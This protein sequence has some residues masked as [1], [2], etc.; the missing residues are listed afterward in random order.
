MNVLSTIEIGQPKTIV[1]YHTQDAT[2]LRKLVTL[3]MMPG[4]EIILEQR[5]PSYI[6]KLGHTRTSIDR[7]TAESIFVQ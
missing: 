1:G 4:I 5:F 3:G 6:I 7:E 2:L